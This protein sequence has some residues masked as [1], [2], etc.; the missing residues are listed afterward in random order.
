LDLDEN[1]DNVSVLTS[2]TFF[3][4]NSELCLPDYFQD[5]L[6]VL[7]PR[8][9]NHSACAPTSKKASSIGTAPTDIETEDLEFVEELAHNIFSEPI[10]VKRQRPRGSK[11]QSGRKESEETQQISNTSNIM[12]MPAEPIIVKRPRP[13]GS[14]SQS[15]RNKS[16]ET[17][18]ISNTS[19][20]IGKP[21]VEKSFDAKNYHMPDIQNK[22][23]ENETSDPGQ[24]IV[25]RPRSGCV[26]DL[27]TLRGTVSSFLSAG[28]DS[29]AINTVTHSLGIDNDMSDNATSMSEWPEDLTLFCLATLLF[30]AR[31]NK[32]NEQKILREDLTFDLII[33]TMS[34]YKDRSAEV[35]TRACGLLWT[36][37]MDPKN[38]KLVVQGGGCNAISDAMVSFMDNNALR[39]MAL[40]SLKVLSRTII[41]SD[42]TLSTVADVMQKHRHN[43]TVQE[44]GCIILGNAAAVDNK[45]RSTP[46]TEKRLEAL[47]RGILAHP[48]S[49]EVQEAACFALMKMAS[50]AGN[51]KLMKS[52]NLLKKALEFMSQKHQ[53]VL[54]QNVSILLRRIESD[55]QESLP[56]MKQHCLD[57]PKQSGLNNAVSQFDHSTW[58][59][60][61]LD[62][63]HENRGDRSFVSNANQSSPRS[64][65]FYNVDE[66]TVHATVVEATVAEPIASIECGSTL[67][68]TD[69]SLLIKR[70]SCPTCGIQTHMSSGIF[71]KRF[72]RPISNE[73]V[74]SGR[75][76]ICIPI[77][78][79]TRHVVDYN[80]QSLGDANETNYEVQCGQLHG[81]GN[82]EAVHVHKN[83]QDLEAENEGKSNDAV[84]PTDN[85]NPPPRVPSF[86][87]RSSSVEQ[88]ISPK[89]K[90]PSPSAPPF[91]S[92][93]PKQ[94]SE[95]GDYTPKPQGSQ[96]KYF[97]KSESCDEVEQWLLSHLPTLQKQDVEKYRDCFVEDGFD[98]TVML[99]VV[100]EGDLSFMKKAHRRFLS[101][102]LQL[103][104]S[105]PNYHCLVL[106]G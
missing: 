17:Q 28:A 64:V 27:Q 54:G 83:A 96:R 49:M 65:S 26:L 106:P 35:L 14:R 5:D 77:N 43:H 99:Q 79:V 23:R 53:E 56:Q 74:L 67:T 92:T 52:N 102:M 37:S 38:R 86:E 45:Q 59:F 30:L 51:V 15:G 72:C 97:S 87:I 66:E 70:G 104:A 94:G 101:K 33:E 18:Q 1:I 93:T 42:E 11:S 39:M 82:R 31:K 47:V 36:L 68:T 85:P 61:P 90:E 24:K 19:N 3:T 91:E 75:C 95:S 105:P 22:S 12:A 41:M 98:S 69:R 10:I 81:S 13:R 40:G 80:G 6:S 34:I 57:A 16:E 2:D 60:R 62:V 44:E 8:T 46:V 71:K 63:E 73:C 76:L 32:K 4:K 84:Q 55:A 88:D 78:V 50:F 21:A 89:S 29:K 100:E 48:E 7:T 9:S 58:R 103:E 25:F 20:I